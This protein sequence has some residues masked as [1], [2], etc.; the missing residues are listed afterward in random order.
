[1]PLDFHS[2][3]QAKNLIYNGKVYELVRGGRKKA[4]AAVEK[5][6]T[7]VEQCDAVAFSMHKRVRAMVAHP[8][9][10]YDDSREL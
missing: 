6:L 1:M 10:S 8:M 3:D 4:V 5:A 7:G 9:L 2:H